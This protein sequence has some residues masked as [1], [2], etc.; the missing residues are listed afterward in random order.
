MVFFDLLRADLEVPPVGRFTGTER[1]FPEIALAV[2]DRPSFVEQEI[3]R[4]SGISAF[5]TVTEGKLFIRVL[6]FFIL[7]CAFSVFFRRL[8]MV[9]APSIFESPAGAA[10]NLSVAFLRL[11]PSGRTLEDSNDKNTKF[12]LR[13]IK[14]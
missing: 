6:S 13:G 5:A 4:T 11:F 12:S 10:T 7:F 9:L 8:L 2:S 14:Y 3:F 1:G